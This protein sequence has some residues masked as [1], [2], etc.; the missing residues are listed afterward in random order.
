M[1]NRANTIHD[2]VVRVL[3][4]RLRNKDRY[5]AVKTKE[6]YSNKPLH[7]DG[8][9][10]I[11]AIR[12]S[13][14]VDYVVLVEVKSGNTQE[15]LEKSLDQLEKDMR[16]A[17]T[18]YPRARFFCFYAYADRTLRKNGYDNPYKICRVSPEKKEGLLKKF[19]DLPVKV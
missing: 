18:L 12:G 8:E 2:G 14:K 7:E 9:F 16:M 15:N 10:D 3:A 11:I 1:S 13:E 5:F 4:E 6:H 17:E 19:E